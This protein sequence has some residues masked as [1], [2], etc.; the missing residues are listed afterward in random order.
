MKKTIW[1][2]SCDIY[3]SIFFKSRMNRMIEA[4][5]QQSPLSFGAFEKLLG[6][7]PWFA[8]RNKGYPSQ[9]IPSWAAV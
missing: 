7:Y 6:T 2:Q 8:S 1:R 5:N 9:P 4:P 3:P